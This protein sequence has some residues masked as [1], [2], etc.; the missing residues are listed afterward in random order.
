MKKL[1]LLFIL[2]VIFVSCTDKAMEENNRST[3]DT[4]NF[5]TSDNAMIP[6]ESSYPSPIPN[7]ETPASTTSKITLEDAKKIAFEDAGVKETDITELDTDTDRE[8]ER[9][10]YEI[11]FKSGGY[12]YE[13]EIDM[14]SGKILKKDKEI[15]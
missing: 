5:K 10:Y 7:A 9:R 1:F 11:D 12:E 14:E 3:T 2:A 4:T 15:D 8:G 6:E 13:Y